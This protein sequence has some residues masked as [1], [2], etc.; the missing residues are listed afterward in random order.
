[1]QMQCG[2]ETQLFQECVKN[3]GGDVAPCQSYMDMMM[4]C[5]ARA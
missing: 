3:T 4:K 5:K 1:M 2:A